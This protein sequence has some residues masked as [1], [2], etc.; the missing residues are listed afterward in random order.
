MGLGADVGGLAMCYRPDL[1]E[2]AGL[3]TGREEVSALWPTWDRYVE[4]GK[5]FAAAE[6]ASALRSAGSRSR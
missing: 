3:P 2:K 1:F 4:T 5:K 6:E